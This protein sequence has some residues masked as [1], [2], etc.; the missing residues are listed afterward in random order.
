MYGGNLGVKSTYS[1][2]SE[3]KKKENRTKGGKRISDFFR[4]EVARPTRATVSLDKRKGLSRRVDQ[5]FRS[6][7]ARRARERKKTHLSQRGND[8]QR[9]VG[10]EPPGRRP[11]SEE[12][13]REEQKDVRP[14]GKAGTS[15]VEGGEGNRLVDVTDCTAGNISTWGDS[16]ENEKTAGGRDCR[17][18]DEASLF[19]PRGGNL[20]GRGYT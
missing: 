15:L 9:R 14:S 13:R 20:K 1:L 18:E 19:T 16:Q 6:R 8:R 4:V 12:G 7:S 3:Y 2:T 17:E 10:G 5:G 11:S